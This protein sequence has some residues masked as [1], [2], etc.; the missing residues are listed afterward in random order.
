M[1]ENE[2]LNELKKIHESKTQKET[3]K[4]FDTVAEEILNKHILVVKNKENEI[5]YRITEI[6]FYY[7]DKCIH[8]DPYV[9]RDYRQ[10]L[11]GEWYFHRNTN[12]LR[13]HTRKGLDITF[14]NNRNY[15][16][17]IIRAIQKINNEGKCEPIEG[18]CNVVN[19]IL[20]IT[21]QT[22]NEY[23][24]KVKNIKKSGIL[25]NNK[26]KLDFSKVDN[27]NNYKAPRVGLKPARNKPDWDYFIMK[28]Y[29]YLLYP[30]KTTKER[31]LLT[32][33]L[34]HEKYNNGLNNS[35]SIINKFNNNE[36]GFPQFDEKSINKYNN[37]YE[38]DEEKRNQKDEKEKFLKELIDKINTNFGVKD[39]CKL[40]GL[41]NEGDEK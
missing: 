34:I 41:L 2:L 3:E 13:T 24:E 27:R 4:A 22:E 26:F 40:Y 17:I 30:R 15:G 28:P 8:P 9:H 20:D 36:N 19:C 33:G 35:V 7:Y 25:K 12:A 38:D 37:Y 1:I 39:K 32:L 16:G 21:K 14:G 10:R 11:F 5:K 6:E 29:R 31:N 23:L 18:P